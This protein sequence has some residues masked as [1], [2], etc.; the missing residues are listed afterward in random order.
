MFG[1]LATEPINVYF[2]NEYILLIVICDFDQTIRLLD[3][4]NENRK[5][6]D[7]FPIWEH[8]P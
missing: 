5:C 2:H 6:S 4:E 3:C 1:F 7:H 8:F